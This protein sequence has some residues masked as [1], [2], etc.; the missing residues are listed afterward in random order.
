MSGDVAQLVERLLCKEEV[1]S[2]SLLV[3]TEHESELTSVVAPPAARSK[4]DAPLGHVH[5]LRGHARASRRCTLTTEEEDERT[6]AALSRVAFEASFANGEPYPIIT[7][8]ERSTP[9][10]VPHP[11]APRGSGWMLEVGQATKGARWMPW[12]KRPM[13]DAVTCEKVRGA[14]SKRRS[15]HI[16]MGKPD[17]VDP[18]HPHLNT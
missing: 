8:V 6:I 11:P 9:P 18:D 12:R 2:S 15:G 17:Q 4:L 14:G 5:G 1:R 16:R 7:R 13:K 10:D 3:S